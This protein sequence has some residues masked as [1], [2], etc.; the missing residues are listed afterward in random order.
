VLKFGTRRLVQAVPLLVAVAFVGFAIMNLAPGGPLVVF[1]HNPHLTA[2]KLHEI[3]V[4]LGLDKPWPQRFVLWLSSLVRGDWGYSYVDGRPVLT[5]IGERIGA[6]FL[7]MGAGFVVALVMAIPLGI[8]GAVRPYGLFDNITTLLSY[9][10]LSMPAFWFGLMLQLFLAVQLGWLPSAGMTS[11]VTTTAPLDVATHL[12]LPATT[13]A[14]TSIAGWSRYVRS[15]LME[16]MRQDYVRTARAKGLAEWAVVV[17][18]GLRNALIPLVTV[19]GLDLPGYFVGATTV[20]VVFSW[21]GMGRLFWTSL[22][23]RDYPVQMGILLISAILII[24]GNLIADT[25]YGALDPRISH[26]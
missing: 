23:G 18:H 12:I 26:E 13:L 8:L 5:V 22:I 14:I 9:F 20:E 2:D 7:L 3:T 11:D 25:A 10:G 6:T 4:N 15:S 19:M 17:K 1:A 24:L 16:A 21:P